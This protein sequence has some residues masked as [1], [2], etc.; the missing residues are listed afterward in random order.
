MKRIW[1]QLLAAMATLGVAGALV[2]ACGLPHNDE[3]VFIRNVIAPPQVQVGAMCTYTADPTLPQLFSGQLDVALSPNYRAILIVGNQMV[4]QAN[5]NQLV[6][7]SNR[8]NIQGAVVRITDASETVQVANYSKLGSGFID[9]ATGTTPGYGLVSVEMIDSATATAAIGANSALGEQA[10]ALGSTTVHRRIAHVKL[11][12]A[13]LGNQSV[14]SSEFVFPIDIC[15]GCLITFPQGSQ[16][17]QEAAA[18]GKPNCDGPL[19][20]SS[21]GAQTIIQPCVLGQ[22]QPVDCRLCVPAGQGPSP[23]KPCN[24]ANFAAGGG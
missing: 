11:F 24:P 19:S 14:E 16:N 4:A 9:P 6:A 18:T 8:V 20:S 22:D 23:E 5:P 3:S 21:S 1:G 13:T 15:H 17:D 10:L 2:A 7:E 12:G